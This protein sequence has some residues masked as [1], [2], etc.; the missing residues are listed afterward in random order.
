MADLPDLSKR[1]V[2]LGAGVHGQIYCATRVAMGFEKPVVLEREQM[3]GGIYMRYAPVPFFL[4]SVNRG[5]ITSTAK[6]PTRIRSLTPADDINYF[7]NCAS[8]VGAECDTE[9]PS[10]LL[11]AQMVR[12]NHGRYS[13]VYPGCD[14]AVTDPFRSKPLISVNG[15][16]AVTVGRLIDARGLRCKDVDGCKP[17]TSLVTADHYLRGQVPDTMLD[18]APKRIAII[19]DG[20][21]ARIVAESLLGQGPKGMRINVTEIGWC[22]P[23]TS[24]WPG[25]SRRLTSPA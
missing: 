10:S 9:Y 13:Q 2:V 12:Q 17:F 22:R 5:S 1:E 6:G 3:P 7:P 16:P 14:V 4:N 21:T 18:G 15:E 24:G 25:T 8:Q 23:V 11:V 19:G 20:D